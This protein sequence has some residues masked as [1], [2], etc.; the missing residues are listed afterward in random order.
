[1]LI[2][3]FSLYRKTYEAYAFAFV[4]G[5]TLDILSAGPF[6]IHT[7]IFMAAVF[8]SGLIVDEDHTKISATFASI[9][10]FATALIFY[11]SLWAVVSYQAKNI[12]FSGIVFSLVQVAFTVGIFFFVFPYF[13]KLFLWEEKVADVRSR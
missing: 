1:M 12:T 8:V 5:L 4:S 11:V 7:T 13:K 10:L 6:G 3:S 9:F 2:V